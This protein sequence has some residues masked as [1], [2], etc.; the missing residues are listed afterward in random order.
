MRIASSFLIIVIGFLAHVSAFSTL[1][2]SATRRPSLR[3][4]ETPENF[5][6]VAATIAEAAG[7]LAGQTIVVKYGGVRCYVITVETIFT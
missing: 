3:L 5:A 7:A 6:D 4:Y 1:T 2:L